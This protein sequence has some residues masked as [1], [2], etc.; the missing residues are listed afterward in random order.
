VGAS[1][2]RRSRSRASSRPVQKR[3]Y[4]PSHSCARASGRVAG[5]AARRRRLGGGSGR[6]RSYTT[7]ALSWPGALP[8]PGDV[9]STPPARREG[10]GGDP[11]SLCDACAAPVRKCAGGGLTPTSPP[12]PRRNTAAPAE[13]EPFAQYSNSAR[14]ARIRWSCGRGPP[15][16]LHG[17]TLKD[18][19]AARAVGRGVQAG[20]PLVAEAALR[21]SWIVVTN[22]ASWSATYS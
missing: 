16:R 6:R 11:T 14:A 3:S 18:A 7:S 8:S 20:T 17:T 5:T 15:R 1:S 21:E 19:R 4:Q 13:V 22:T 10:A 9:G 12:T 2:S